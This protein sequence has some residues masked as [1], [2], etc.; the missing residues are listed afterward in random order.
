[1]KNTVRVIALAVIAFAMYSLFVFLIPFE[2][3][4]VFWLGY[5]FALVAF[6]VMGAWPVLALFTVWHS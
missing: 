2:Q 5:L 1:M 4:E 6:V 3:T